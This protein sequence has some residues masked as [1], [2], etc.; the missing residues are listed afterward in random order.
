MS[1]TNRGLT[2]AGLDYYRTPAWSVAAILPYLPE[3]P[4]SVLDPGCGDGAIG[5]AAAEAFDVPIIGW[6]LDEDRARA[7]EDS[8]DYTTVHHADYLA[9]ASGRLADPLIIGNPPYSLAME[10]VL[11]SLKLARETGGEWAVCMLLRLPWIASAGRRAFH[12]ANPADI[13]VLP[14]RPS[15]CWS[16]TY[17]MR[18]DGCGGVSK[19]IERVAVGMRA[20]PKGARY[21]EPCKECGLVVR[22]VGHR[23]TVADS[24]DYAWFVWTPR[25]GG[26][27]EVL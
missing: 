5:A 21:H 25:G 17:T 14:R 18:C 15:F 27:W 22:Q 11:Q 6:E 12:Q 4:L 16:H 3:F 26:L 7:A 1:S 24:C 10:F 2:R 13:H 9:G 19:V 8:G 20:G 23:T